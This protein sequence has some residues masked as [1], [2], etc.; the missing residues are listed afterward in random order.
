MPTPSPDNL[1]LDRRTA[2]GAS[3]AFLIFCLAVLT[4]L[5]WWKLAAL[6][7]WAAAF[8]ALVILPFYRLY[9]ERPV[10]DEGLPDSG[11]SPKSD[12]IACGEARIAIDATIRE[13]LAISPSDRFPI[14]EDD[15]WIVSFAFAVIR[16]IVFLLSGYPMQHP[17]GYRGWLKETAFVAAV[18]AAAIAGAKLRQFH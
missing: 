17:S 16:W 11:L 18:I 9:V 6:A 5:G 8:V 4:A 14:L 12:G 7:I 15:S 2:I 10:Y 3:I 1:A 13:K